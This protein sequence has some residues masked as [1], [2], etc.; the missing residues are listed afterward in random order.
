MGQIALQLSEPLHPG[1]EEPG[2][3]SPRAVKLNLGFGA[4]F[5]HQPELQEALLRDQQPQIQGRAGALSSQL[6]LLLQRGAPGLW[7]N[8]V[9]WAVPASGIPGSPADRWT[10][11]APLLFP[12][13]AGG[14][15]H[16]LYCF[17]T[18]SQLPGC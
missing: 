9:S 4:V 3:P 16:S 14:P 8:T 1:R 5:V 7:G 2:S 6:E 18:T 13:K 10:A 15:T 12:T 11:P 17:F